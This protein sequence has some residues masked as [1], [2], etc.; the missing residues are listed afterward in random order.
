MVLMSSIRGSIQREHSEGAFRG[1]IRSGRE[2]KGEGNIKYN[3]VEYLNYLVFSF[4]E[5]DASK[6]CCSAGVS[7]TLNYHIRF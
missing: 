7:L 4:W 1:S 2:L 6:K 3:S 5:H